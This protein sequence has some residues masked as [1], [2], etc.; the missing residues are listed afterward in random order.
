MSNSES[1]PLVPGQVVVGE[2]ELHIGTDAERLIV[3]S[4]L[5]DRPIQVGSHFHFA[6]ANEALSFDRQAA[7]GCR[8]AIPAG[9]AVRFEPG[10]EREVGLV[11]LG[12]NRIVPGLRGLTGGSLDRPEVGTL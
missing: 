11:S 3:V 1:T 5:A 7:W 4:N 10:I 2:E 12:G 8:L 9:T 6:E